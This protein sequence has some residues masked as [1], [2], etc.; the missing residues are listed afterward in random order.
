M[1]ALSVVGANLI[2]ESMVPLTA[3]NGGK[4][5]SNP[6]AGATAPTFPHQDASDITNADRAGAGILTV[7]V[8]TG[9]I[10]CAWWLV[11]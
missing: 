10:G 4:S 3:D 6:D 7:I 2:S 1:T 5:V 11:R 8:V 9:V